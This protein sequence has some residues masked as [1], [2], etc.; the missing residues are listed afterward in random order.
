MGNS[1]GVAEVLLVVAAPGNE[2]RHVSCW[3]TCKTHRQER[4]EQ[5]RKKEE[6]GIERMKEQFEMR[7]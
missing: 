6:R 3:N 1:Q 2:E 5:A 7:K 4:E